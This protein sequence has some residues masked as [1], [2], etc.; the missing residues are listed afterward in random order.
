MVITLA[1]FPLTNNKEDVP[2]SSQHCGFSIKFDRFGSR[3]LTNYVEGDMLHN[4]DEKFI[5]N[6]VLFLNSLLCG[7]FNIEIIIIVNV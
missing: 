6:L 3:L 4:A 2:K 5:F 7:T 1:L